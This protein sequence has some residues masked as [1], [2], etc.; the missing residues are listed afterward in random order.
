MNSGAL[1]PMARYTLVFV[2]SRPRSSGQ[3]LVDHASARRPAISTMR[4]AV[5]LVMESSSVG[6]H[7]WRARSPARPDPSER[8]DPSLTTLSLQMEKV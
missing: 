4:F 3:V 7:P 2:Q 1:T 6:T 8:R 5:V